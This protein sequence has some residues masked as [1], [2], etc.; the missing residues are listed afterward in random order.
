VIEVVVE[1]RAWRAAAPKARAL[2]KAAAAAT[3]AV[4]SQPKSAGLA[5]LL[6]DDA[7]LRAL[8]AAFRGKDA[9]TNVLSFPAAGAAGH[10]GDVALALGVCAREAADQGKSLAD[11][12]Q[13]LTAHGV[14][15][16]LGYDHTT[17][18]EAQVMEAKERAILA[19]LGVADPY[20]PRGPQGD[21]GR[22]DP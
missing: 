5:I 17:D 4:E 20:A 11:H 15:H 22:H 1:A 2:A 8:N 3:L 10:L 13:H 6:A 21:H 14:L 19:G 16:L 18:A 12:L 9:A 7:R